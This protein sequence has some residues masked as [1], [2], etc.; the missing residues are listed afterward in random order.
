[1]SLKSEIL[2]LDKSG[3]LAKLKTTLSDLDNS[4]QKVAPVLGMLRHQVRKTEGELASVEK[5][6]PAESLAPSALR[7]AKLYEDVFR[8]HVLSGLMGEAAYMA[9][10]FADCRALMEARKLAS[11]AAKMGGASNIKAVER[12]R[13]ALKSGASPADVLKAVKGTAKS[14]VKAEK[15]KASAS[16]KAREEREA[17]AKAEREAFSAWKASGSTATATAPAPPPPVD[18]PPAAMESIKGIIDALPPRQR[19]HMPDMLRA[20][21]EYMETSTREAAPATNIVPMKKAA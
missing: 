2:A 20:L 8:E 3:A 18:T 6:F 11:L 10:S 14:A 19:A 7:N 12:E 16:E 15:E 1:M 13:E 9:L 5:S 4:A 21:A 17:S